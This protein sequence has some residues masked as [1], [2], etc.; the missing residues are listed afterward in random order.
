MPSIDAKPRRVN[1]LSPIKCHSLL[2]RFLFWLW[3]RGFI[4]NFL[5]G[6]FAIL[7]LM[8]TLWI[9]NWVASWLRALVGADSFIGGGLRDL[10]L[11]F[12]ANQYVATAIGWLLVISC[13]WLLGLFVSGTALNRWQVWFDGTF[14]RIPLVKSIYGPVKQVVEMFSNQD[15]SAM[16]G[17]RVVHCSIGED[18]SASFLGL[19]PSNDIYRFKDQDCHIVYLPSAP[20]PMTGFNMFI[21]VDRVTNVEMDVEQLMQVYFSLGVMTASVVPEKIN[22]TA[23]SDQDD[24]KHLES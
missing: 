4:S 1:P 21:P 24:E 13:I 14:R 12:A 11:Q 23:S 18:E 17:M 15:E 9:M 8:I 3:K 22:R 2:K 16:S 5:T 6:L 19:L 10:G 20:M 7:P